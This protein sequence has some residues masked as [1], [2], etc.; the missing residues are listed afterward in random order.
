MN[1]KYHF[2]ITNIILPIYFPVLLC[3]NIIKYHIYDLFSDCLHFQT[4][5]AEMIKSLNMDPSVFK[6]NYKKMKSFLKMKTQTV[7][8]HLYNYGNRRLWFQTMCLWL[9]NICGALHWPNECGCMQNDLGGRHPDLGSL[10]CSTHTIIISLS[11]FALFINHFGCEKI[12]KI[13]G[14]GCIAIAKR[15][16]LGYI[17]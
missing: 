11:I 15:R 9:S 4:S 2:Y 8:P 5:Y 17:Q 6:L 14:R 16:V 7:R 3:K 1:A 13:Y 10:R 12:V